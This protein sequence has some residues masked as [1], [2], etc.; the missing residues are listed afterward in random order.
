MLYP[1]IFREIL[2]KFLLVSG[3]AV[4]RV[5]ENNGTGT[6][7]PLVNGEQITGHGWPPVVS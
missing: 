1:A 5:V 2:V 7:C 3:N 4:S 6:G